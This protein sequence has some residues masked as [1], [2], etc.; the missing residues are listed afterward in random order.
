MTK[1]EIIYWLRKNKI[2]RF[3]MWPLESTR[4]IL[5]QNRYLKS[6]DS[7]FVRSLRDTYSGQRCFIIGNGPSLRPEDLDKLTG[8][9][10]FAANLIYHIYPLTN[11][12]PT[13]Y[14]SVD[15]DVLVAEMDNIKKSGDYIKF[16]NYKGKRYGR[17]QSD[18]IWYLFVNGRFHIDPYR[19]D[20]IAL[21]EDV[22]HHLNFTAT[23]TVYAIELAIYMG[24]KEIFLLGIDNNYARRREKDGKI[25]ND[26]TVTATY[27]FEGMKNEKGNQKHDI[28]IQNV[29]MFEQSYIS[30]RQFAEEHGVKIYN[31]TR[32]GKL[33]VFERVDFDSLFSDKG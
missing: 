18:N 23:V 28:F 31:A 7:A 5:L 30:A 4:R 24:F 17:K 10:T 27:F 25:Y 32:G 8:E 16:I 11:W 21:N 12:R 6:K 33:E 3:F 2:V 14:T 15:N 19:F 26:P 20:T 22:S 9:V 13:Y 1:Q 29:E